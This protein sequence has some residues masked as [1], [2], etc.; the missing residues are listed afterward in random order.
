MLTTRLWGFDINDTLMYEDIT[1]NGQDA[2]TTS[3]SDWKTVFYLEPLTYGSGKAVAGNCIITNIAVSAT[4][5][6]I[7]AAGFQSSICNFYIPKNSI[8]FFEMDVWFTN[9]TTAYDAVTVNQYLGDGATQEVLQP[10]KT[11]ALTSGIADLDTKGGKLSGIM[12]PG[13]NI[14]KGLDIGTTAQTL[15]FSITWGFRYV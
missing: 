6:G 14:F 1:C 2:V 15:N 10:V 12:K 4:Y 11:I 5:L 9:D 13:H 7:S 3:N 8:G